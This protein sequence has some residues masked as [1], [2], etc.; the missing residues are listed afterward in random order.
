VLAETASARRERVV[1][2]VVVVT[3]V[4][5]EA[6]FLG[7][8]FAFFVGE[9]LDALFLSSSILSLAQWGTFLD[10]KVDILSDSFWPVAC[11]LN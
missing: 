5:R 7:L 6:F 9:D 3:L 4:V 1:I 10:L 8:V 11:L 2:V